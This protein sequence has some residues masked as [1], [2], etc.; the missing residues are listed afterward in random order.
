MYLQ[1]LMKYPLARAN[2]E[3]LKNDVD[4]AVKFFQENPDATAMPFMHSFP[5][6]A[7][8]RSAGLLAAALAV[9]YKNRRVIFVKGRCNRNGE[10]H[11][12]LEI[13]TV[14][15]DPTAHQFEEINAPL[16]CIKPNPLEA[17]FRRDQEF[18]DLHTSTDLPAR[19]NGRWDAALIALC[20][21][22][23]A[24]SFRT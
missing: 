11:F 17:K 8:E 7:C 22:I 13:D 18:E 19:S 15:V 20:N 2:F 21:A 3:S 12:W 6:N 4:I 14:V 10:M 1:D 24:E 23:Q 5:K 16:I 9:K